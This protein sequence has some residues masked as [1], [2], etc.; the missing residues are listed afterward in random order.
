MTGSTMIQPGIQELA[1]IVNQ[2]QTTVPR[3]GG[4]T[5][6]LLEQFPLRGLNGSI[7]LPDL[8]AFKALVDQKGGAFKAANGEVQ[9]LAPETAKALEQLTKPGN[10]ALFYALSNL[11]TSD[12]TS[13]RWDSADTDVMKSSPTNSWFGSPT[14]RD[15]AQQGATTLFN[16]RGQKS[17]EQWLTSL[18]QYGT[19]GRFTQLASLG[20]GADWLP[21][22][23]DDTSAKLLKEY[24]TL[25]ETN[26]ANAATTPPGL[27]Q[28][29][30]ELPKPP[31][32]QRA[33][34]P[35]SKP[36]DLTSANTP[37]SAL[38]VATG[39]GLGGGLAGGLALLDHKLGPELLPP[40][41]KAPILLGT[42]AL[43]ALAGYFAG[44]N[45]QQA[46]GNN[47]A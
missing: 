2:F 17:H 34:N 4:T 33:G 38:S 21:K 14:V 15:L 20:E 42:A 36:V 25:I 40:R 37:N 9:T 7:G 35:N 41:W 47:L 44:N 46:Q 39:L 19:T 6:E 23:D 26:T 30:P 27:Q 45:A 22:S 31:Q 5:P 12:K 13:G 10:E 1:T 8:R 43:G 18:K 32:A 28:P 29:V 3:D 16:A 11:D 24:Y